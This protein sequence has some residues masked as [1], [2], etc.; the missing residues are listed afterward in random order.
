M[1]VGYE[2]YSESVRIRR[3]IYRND[4]VAHG[5][6]LSVDNPVASC[7]K[8]DY[9]HAKAAC[10][11]SLSVRVV[12]LPDRPVENESG[13]V[14]YDESHRSYE[15]DSRP[16]VGYVFKPAVNGF[17][18]NKHSRYGAQRKERIHRYDGNPHR[19]VLQPCV[20]GSQPPEQPY[21]NVYVHRDVEGG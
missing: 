5:Y 16:V 21:D 20:A 15:Q 14:S 7:P 9:Y 8:D 6:I 12:F 18:R 19:R 2:G 17:C 4:L 10:Y 3:L 11:E 13:S 1:K